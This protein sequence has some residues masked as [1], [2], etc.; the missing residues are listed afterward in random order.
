MVCERAK[1]EEKAFC[2]IEREVVGVDHQQLG[3]GLAEAWKFPRSC[4][5]VAGY[6]HQPMQ[7]SKDR[8]LVTVVHVADILCAQS[9]KGFNLTAMRQEIDASLLAELNL[10]SASLEQ[11]KTTIPTLISDAASVF[12]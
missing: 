10:D 12:G 5:L 1:S 3:A 6:H 11:F 4:Q 7:L 2:E 8:V 9:A